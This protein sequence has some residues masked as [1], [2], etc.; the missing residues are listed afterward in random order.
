MGIEADIQRLFAKV[1]QKYGG[2]K[3]AAAASLDVNNVTFWGWVTGKRQINPA[4]CKA[5]DRAG[6]VLLLPGERTQTSAKSDDDLE[7]MRE[8][9]AVL[10]HEISLMERERTALNEAND[11]LK[12]LVSQL[13][14]DS[15]E[16]KLLPGTQKTRPVPPLPSRDGSRDQ[17]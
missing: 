1:L 5:I 10:E 16:K 3:A 7:K 17:R 12:K 6:G 11:A 14:N 9:V 2:N 8:R 15:A 13:E 4:L